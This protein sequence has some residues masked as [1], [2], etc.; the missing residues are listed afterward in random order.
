M[1]KKLVKDI[2]AK[3]KD[4]RLGRIDESTGNYLRG[5]FNNL[6]GVIEDISL[7]STIDK[8]DWKKLNTAISQALGVFKK[9][10]KGK[11]LIGW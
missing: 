5:L 10:L 11:G 4:F 7:S 9:V 3:W 6:S 2:N 8:A 1:E